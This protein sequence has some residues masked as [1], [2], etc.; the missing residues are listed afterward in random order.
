MRLVQSPQEFV[1]SIGKTSFPMALD[2]LKRSD[3]WNSLSTPD[4]IRNLIN[5][6]RLTDRIIYVAQSL[7]KKQFPH[8]NGFKIL[9][10]V[11]PILLNVFP[12]IAYKSTMLTI[13]TG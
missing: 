13:A 8:V 3:I 11:K 2:S 6:E 5:G 12:I 10:C 9:Y 1:F 7:L 4:D